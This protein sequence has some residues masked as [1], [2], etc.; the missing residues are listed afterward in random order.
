[1]FALENYIR[2]VP[3]FPKKGIGFKDITTLIKNGPVF[4]QA[5]NQLAEKFN[6]LGIDLVVGIESRGF[7][8]ASALAFKW[9]AGVVP[10]R[11]PGKLPAKCIR[12]EYALEYGTDAIEIHEDAIEKGQKVLIIDDLLATGGTVAATIKLLNRLEAEIV[13][14]GFLIEL[15]FLN[16]RKQ[17]APYPVHSLIHYQCE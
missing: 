11:K 5:I 15:D 17:L 16:G 14:I 1:M 4:Q 9:E 12:E 13:G 7:I 10:V 6:R 3:D 8:F 2:N